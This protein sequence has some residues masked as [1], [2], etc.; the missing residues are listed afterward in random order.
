MCSAA[1]WVA[2]Q[3]RAIYATPLRH[4]QALR[5]LTTPEVAEKW[6]A[7]SAQGQPVENTLTYDRK[8]RR[9]LLNGAEVK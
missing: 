7:H 9:V 4:L 5:E 8:N 3:A 2:S 6:F 1:Y